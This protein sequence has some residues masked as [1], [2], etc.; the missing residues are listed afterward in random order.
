[1]SRTQKI[2]VSFVGVILA[3]ILLLMLPI[4][5]RNGET[6]T[7][8]GAL[9]TSVSATCVTGLVV[10]D[11]F[12]H[13]TLFGQLVILLLIQIGGLGFI[14]FGMFTMIVLGRRI[15]LAGRE[16]IQESLN[17]P[18]LRGNVR[19]VRRIFCGTVFFEGVGA[20]LLSIR[21]VPQM[22]VSKGIYYG[23]FHSV[24]SFCNA[25]FDLMGF[26]EEY[27]SF[28]AYAG[29]PLVNIVVM[30]LI[31]I[32]GLGFFVW[33]D[34]WENRLHWH[35]YMLQTKVV[36]TVTAVLIAGGTILFLITERGGV[37]AGMNPGERTLA[38]LF[39]SI[40]PRTAGFN[41]VDTASLSN[42]GKLLTMALMFIGGSPGSTAGGIKTTTLAV[43]VIYVGAYLFHNKDCVIFHRRLDSESI[44]RACI[45]LFINFTLAF[46][47]VIL[48]L[49]V[50]EN[51]AMS[52]V[53]FEAFSAI[54]TS[55]MSTGVTRDLNLV[56]R[57]AIA[58]LMFLGRVGSLSFALILTENRKEEK[59]RYPEE[60][61][62][63]G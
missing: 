1:M 31:V 13:W 50:Q 62:T 16:L 26:Q 42:P 36:L 37:F 3:G 54:G 45:I 56:S 19:L 63:V 39:S 53:L 58:L 48:I 47:A 57:L 10:Y 15:G 29:D 9:F 38:A 11:T 51:L 43:I 44:K 6:T 49:T 4:S 24:S 46:A 21:F 8:S 12:T 25:G 32:G 34:L 61:I 23:I 17:T 22:G 41:S 33:D 35:R 2:I 27:S 60:E 30:T 7:L 5:T 14:T 59:V 18:H 20:V 55:G 52:D 40:T 28:T